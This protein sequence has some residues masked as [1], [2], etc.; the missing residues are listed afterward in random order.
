MKDTKIKE[1]L[2]KDQNVSLKANRVFDNF[3]EN[4]EIEK[5][6]SNN[7]NSNKK[8]ATFYVFKKI[9]TY[10]ACFFII[11]AG[12]NVY[13]HSKGYDNIFFLIKDLTTYKKVEDPN[14]IFSDQDIIIS[15][16]FFQITNNVEMQVNELQI[17]DNKARLFLLV[18]ELKQNDETPFTYKVYNDNGTIM[19]DSKSI[20]DGSK[21][22]YTEI[23]ELNNYKDNTKKIKLEIFDNENKLLKTVTIDLDEK[24]IEAK[25]E[26]IEV[27]KI[28]QIELNRFL[29]E[30]TE[31]LY[32][33]K[34]I[35]E[36]EVIILE[37]YDIY[38]SDGKYTVRYLYMIPDKKAFDDN[39]V[40]DSD[41][42]INSAQ[43]KYENNIYKLVNIEVPSKFL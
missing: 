32:S 15:Y 27:K 12:S 2:K 8:V 20:S 16:S 42:Y 38:Y 25:T 17:K 29:K 5:E 37:T 43:F 6:N 40:E 22:V 24:T 11:I 28:S 31:K 7:L 41:I 18:K 34:D 4:L 30:E 39:T 36:K 1:Y 19:Y 14:E 33:K 35:E 9:L 26:N 21:L 23:L 13:A 3:I 10:A